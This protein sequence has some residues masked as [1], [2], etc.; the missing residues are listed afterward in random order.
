RYKRNELGLRTAL[1][2]CGSSISSA[3]SALVASGVLAGLDCT[4]GFTAW[5]FDF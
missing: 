4:L 5:R 1:L 3:F 2:T